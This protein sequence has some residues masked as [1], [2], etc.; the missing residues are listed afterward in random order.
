MR[1]LIQAYN[2]QE[3]P[4]RTIVS[5]IVL[6]GFLLS[7]GCQ[8]NSLDP[9]APLELTSSPIAETLS[10]SVPVSPTGG[11]TQMTPFLPTSANPDLHILIEKAKEDLAH[12]LSISA[13]QI[14]L[15]EAREVVW[16]DASLGCPQPGMAYAQVQVDGLLIRLGVGKEMYLYHTGGTADPFLC[17]STSPVIPNVTPKTDEF[18]PPPDSEID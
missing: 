14:N 9:T 18:V 1:A 17:E 3:V 11:D 13:T 8:A 2:I 12:R 4:L 15:L 7:I 6:W 16:P 10:P 5:F